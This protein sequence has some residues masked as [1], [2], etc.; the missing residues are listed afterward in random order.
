MKARRFR[1][2]SGRYDLLQDGERIAFVIVAHRRSPEGDVR[3]LVAVH[4]ESGHRIFRGHDGA[5][6]IHQALRHV[7]PGRLVWPW[8]HGCDERGFRIKA[9]GRAPWAQP[10]RVA[11]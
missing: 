5:W 11:A 10:Y 8:Y 2:F 4:D 9:L 3:H 1:D 7:V 6:T